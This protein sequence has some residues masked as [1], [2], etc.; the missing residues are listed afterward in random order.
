LN[1]SGRRTERDA[2]ERL[3]AD[4]K[5]GRSGA[6]V[7]RGEAGIGKTALLEHARDSAVTSGFRVESLVGAE[8]EAQLGFA[9]LHQLC[10]PVLDRA[11]TLPEPQQA[12][13]E[14]AFGL[15]VGVVPD[16]FL[17]GLAT[18]NLLAEIAEDAPLLCLVDDAQ[19]LDHVSSQ[20]LAF[21]ARRLEAEQLAMVFALRESTDGDKGLFAGL[22]ELRLSG[23][24]ETEARELLAA[25]VRAPLDDRVRDRIISEARGNPLALLELPRSSRT[26]G[27]TSGF[28][29]PDALDVP[30]CVRPE[31]KGLPRSA[32]AP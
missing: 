6:L 23:L 12:A 10:A 9:G 26:V 28:E 29:L 13:L 15:R 18:L 16:R 31:H 22:P 19:W 20:V 4:A 32:T 30:R 7:V 25:E 21:V 17:V 14:V 5:A 1:L 3:L 2:V 24:G 27:L 8:S 11:R